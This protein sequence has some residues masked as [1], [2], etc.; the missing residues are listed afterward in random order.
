M[1]HVICLVSVGVTCNNGL[2]NVGVTCNMSCECR[3]Y[4]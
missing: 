2:V 1:L 4:M 3:C